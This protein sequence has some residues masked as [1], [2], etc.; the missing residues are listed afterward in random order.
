SVIFL[1][2][3]IDRAVLLAAG[4]GTRM[5]ELTN[6]LP[7]PMIAVRGKPIL[8]HIVEG[9][10]VAGVTKFLII[11]GYRA[12]VVRQLFGDGSRFGVA[13]DYATQ[14]VQDGTGKVVELARDFVAEDSFTLNY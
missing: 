13:I 1:M 3:K 4:R 2:A 5:R 6:D 10:R 14:V 12:E 7:K 11:V 9:L 8:L